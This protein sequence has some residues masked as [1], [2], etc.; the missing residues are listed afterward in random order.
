MTLCK[1]ISR[2]RYVWCVLLSCSF[3]VTSIAYAENKTF[4][5]KLLEQVNQRVQNIDTEQLEAQLKKQ[6]QTVMID[7]RT[8]SEILLLGGMIDAPRSYMVNRGWL[9]FRINELVPDKDTPIVVYCGINLRSPLAADVLMKMGYSQVKNYA[10][11][12]FVWRDKGL[13]IEAPDLALDSM[14]FS[15][16]VQVAKGVWSAIGATEPGSYEN[17]GHNN[18]LSFIITDEGVLVVN[19][20]DNYLL[21]RSLHE[22]IKKLTNQPVRFVV[23]ENGQGHAAMGSAYW[24]E[25]GAHIIAHKDTVA[26]LQ[27]N[28]AQ[29][30]QRVLTRSRDKGMGTRLVLPDESFEDKKIIEMGGTRIELIHFGSAHSPGDVS[31]WLPQQ[32]IIIAGD[33][34]FHQRMLPVSERTDTAAWIKTW[35]KF[36][37]VGAKIVVPGHGAVT[38]MQVV[39][40]YTKG[41]LMSMREQI[42]AL[43]EAGGSLDELDEIDQSAYSHLDT[44]DE[45]ARLNASIM[46]RA[47][48]FE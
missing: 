13:P 3:F 31:V 4:A 1:T 8:A 25:Q 11:G 15:K 29:I 23:L 30:L 2:Q 41:Y 40:K 34:A 9:E 6:P 46:F 18:N 21:A 33:I 39:T 14:L 36:E 17:S 43:L 35:D 16:P 5:E 26:E 28:G 20:S 45:L 7:V 32:K 37:A 12:F 27:A 22:E 47:M 19:A 10:D 48:E 38:N 24:K 42:A 44:F